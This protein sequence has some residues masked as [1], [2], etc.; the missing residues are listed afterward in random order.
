M[1]EALARHDSALVRVFSSYG[2][3]WSKGTGDGFAAAFDSESQAV[4][5]AIEAQQAIGELSVE[6][7]L[8]IRVGIH[9]G[10]VVE[11]DGDLFGPT[12]NRAARIM[13]TAHGG[14]SIVSDT[15]IASVDVGDVAIT[16]LGNHRLKDLSDPVRLFQVDAPDSTRVF[17]RLRSLPALTNLP[18]DRSSFIG[19]DRET[20]DLSELIGRHRLV[21]LIGPGGV[22]KTRLAAHAVAEIAD[23]HPHGVWFIPLAAVR[24]GNDI[25]DETARILGI[26]SEGAASGV[27]ALED[28]VRTR[29][30]LLLIDNCEHVIDDVAELTERLLATSQDIRIVATSREPLGLTEEEVVRVDPLPTEPHEAAVQL[31]IDRATSAGATIDPHDPAISR[32]C[33]RLDGLALAIELAAAKTRTLRLADLE[34]RLDNRF[35]VLTRARGG[36][37]HHQT[38]AAT[39]A[40]SYDLASEAER[41]V[42]NRLSVFPGLFSMEWASRTAGYEPL[43]ALEAIEALERLHDRSLVASVSTQDA[44][45]YYLLESIKDFA[46]A[47]RSDTA[48]TEAER[49]LREVVTELATQRPVNG[50][51]AESAWLAALHR[52]AP[53]LRGALAAAHRELDFSGLASLV[54]GAAPY[55]VA[56]GSADEGVRW[57]ELAISMAEPDADLREALGDLYLSANR[58]QD[59]DSVYQALLSDL[60]PEDQVR[61]ARLT[62]KMA[63]RSTMVTTQLR[64]RTGASLMGEALDWL[65]TPADDWPDDRLQEWIN[66]QLDM[67]GIGYFGFDAERQ[68]DAIEAV[69]PWLFRATPRQGVEFEIVERGLQYQLTRYRPSPGLPVREAEFR[70]VGPANQ[71]AY[72]SALFRTAF[73]ELLVDEVEAAHAHLAESA[74]IAERLGGDLRL[75]R[76]YAYHSLASRR[77]GRTDECRLLAERT[78]RHATHAEH[79]SYIAVA[80]ANLGW[81][82]LQD[83]NSADARQLLE[84]AALRMATK[85]RPYPF[86]WI[87]LLPLLQIQSESSEWEA[88]RATAEELLDPGLQQLPDDLAAALLNARESPDRE[89]LELVLAG[90]KEHQLL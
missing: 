88:A 51:D 11:R 83:G 70:G 43:S 57:A 68:R 33:A 5:A 59:A 7:E 24:S 34:L 62:R 36:A 35:S 23:R 89:T 10:D 1:S 4:R 86:R 9:T 84:G 64:S 38:L 73:Y 80:E 25:A 46:A 15:T 41:V 72:G 2:V 85:A 69:R 26:L 71:D 31:F 21:T 90:A 32:V 30:L 3:L 77:L 42:L 56:A 53:S 22:G 81:C 48:D 58:N 66:L 49:R 74:E 44:E 6:P 19:R 13:S 28:H 65:G 87:A 29:S 16:A 75:A 61:R 50:S 45:R 37:H 39:I 78:L 60:S 52:N 27:T 82:A 18:I 47:R 8:R 79:H 20:A 14:Q 17:P 76:V 40:W 63:S 67:A 12:M 55:W 54:I